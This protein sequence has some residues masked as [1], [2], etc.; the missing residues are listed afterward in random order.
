MKTN[1][2]MN[3]IFPWIIF[4]LGIWYFCIRILGYNLEYIPG[5]L[6]DS[7]FINYL[8]EHGYKW[9]TG[10]IHAFW[11]A[12]F[13]Y[14]FKNTIALSDTMLGTMPVYAVWR[15]FGFGPESSYQLWW[16]SIC[17]LNYWVSY[18]VFKKW[19]NRYD[20]AII[21]AWI[22]AFTI[23]NIGQLNYMQMIIRFLVPLV[24]YSAFKMVLSPS[25]KYLAIYCFGIVFQFYCAMY[26]G[27]YL[28]YFSVLFILFYYV[29]SKHWKQLSYYFSKRK[30]V[31]TI[32]VIILSLLG[33]LWLFIPYFRMAKI[34][35][36]T[37]YSSVM[38][39][40]PVWN[41]YLFP[42]ESSVTWRFLFSFAKPDVP[43]WWLQYLFTGLI[44]FLAMVIS[45]FYLIYNWYRKKEKP[46]FIKS[47]IITSI[48]IVLFHLRTKSGYSMYALLYHLPGMNSM[49]V[50]MRFMNVELFLLL[51]IAG[52]F[53]I[54]IQ[55]K[56]FLLLMALVFVDILFKPELIPAK[57][58]AELTER[59]ERLLNEMAKFDLHKYK[60][61]ALIDSSEK[62]YVTNIDMMWVAQSLG[63]KTINGYSS[64]CPHELVEFVKTNTEQGLDHWLV[65]QNIRRDE[66]LLLKRKSKYVY[67]IARSQALSGVKTENK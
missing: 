27:F 64:N 43:V 33:M 59:K 8:L 53:L 5:D 66:I 42:H 49:R 35:G 1:Q 10:N 29:L 32:F 38:P 54:K 62:A 17:T 52:Q 19:F 57:E 65:I 20:I 6:G 55:S 9:L 61:V 56:Y 40:I 39:N 11:N 13:M 67:A 34:V 31:Y 16:I 24:F 15:F 18:V 12:G 46:V 2:I 14:P 4:L 50:V 3:R 23:Y 63:I 22:F 21:L 37:N 47:V 7:R 44:P 58:K 48:I 45:P 28:L 25:I 51:I 41:S 36:M 30:L 60:A 26:T